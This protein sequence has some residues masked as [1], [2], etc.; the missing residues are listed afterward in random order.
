MRLSSSQI[1]GVP[2]DYLFERITDFDSFESYIHTEG[3]MAERTDNVA[4]TQSGMS[5]HVSGTF[6]K[7]QRNVDL[8]LENYAP[9]DKLKYVCETS[10]MNAA[11]FFELTEITPDQ[12]ELSLYIDPEAR[13]ISARLVLQSVKLAKKT[14]ER[15]I[16]QRIE[17]FGNQIEADF[18]FLKSA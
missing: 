12:T 17:R 7:K 11:I 10:S 18:K 15:R 2:K 8:T 1:I 3:G 16:T 9:S 13:N 14:I 4:G 6:R 5:W